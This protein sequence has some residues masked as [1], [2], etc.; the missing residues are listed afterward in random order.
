MGALTAHWQRNLNFTSI[1]WKSSYII[2]L[3]HLALCTICAFYWVGSTQY[4]H[5]W[6][7]NSFL[8]LLLPRRRKQFIHFV[9]IECLYIL[10][11]LT[12]SLQVKRPQRR[13]IEINQKIHKPS[14][15]IQWF[16]LIWPLLKRKMSLCYIS[17]MDYVTLKKKYV[18]G[19][20]GFKIKKYIFYIFFSCWIRLQSNTPNHAF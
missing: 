1:E 3:F 10:I 13:K 2:S 15:L 18:N 12:C 14:T 5:N 9:C 19:F 7:V 6:V 20:S 17:K 11:K 8:F 4:L 16:T